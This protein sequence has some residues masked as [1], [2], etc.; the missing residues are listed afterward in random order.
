MFYISS[1]QARAL[2]DG[3]R[4]AY[5]ASLD[6]RSND[7]DDTD[8]SDG[9]SVVYN[10]RV[11]ERST[12]QHVRLTVVIV[13]RPQSDRS[14]LENVE[15]MQNLVHQQRHHSTTSDLDHVR[16]K[17]DRAQDRIG[18]RQ[19]LM[20]GMKRSPT[21]IL[22]LSDHSEFT[23]GVEEESVVTRVDVTNLCQHDALVLLRFDAVSSRFRSERRQTERED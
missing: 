23:I 1:R 5:V 8:Q 19:T 17:E 2:C 10:Q 11:S 7:T 20:K 6:E 16:A 12:I 21:W 18:R 3:E 4:G 13:E 22:P 14:D 9:E 15:R